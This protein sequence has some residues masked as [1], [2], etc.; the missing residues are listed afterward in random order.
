MLLQV[1]ATSVTSTPRPTMLQPHHLQ[2]QT[3][4]LEALAEALQA[5]LPVQL[6]LPSLLAILCSS[7]AA[8]STNLFPVQASCI[9][10]SQY[11]CRIEGMACV[12]A[13]PSGCCISMQA[14]QEAQGLRRMQLGSCC[15]TAGHA[16]PRPDC[17]TAAPGKILTR[18]ADQLLGHSRHAEP[19]AK[20]VGALQVHVAFISAG[21]SPELHRALQ[22]A[23]AA[24]AVKLHRPCQTQKLFTSCSPEGGT[25]EG[26]RLQAGSLMAAANGG[27]S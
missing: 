3:L 14:T 24:A 27:C 13:A 21:P 1:S 20:D 19:H 10:Q 7:A 22:V 9:T 17:C 15:Y 18:H 6:P 25:P 11:S 23:A 4:D 2:P 26:W 8:G 16:A 12:L 5:Q